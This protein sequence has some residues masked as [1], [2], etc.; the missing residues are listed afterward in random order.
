MTLPILRTTEGLRAR[1]REWRCAG[2]SVG[3][4]P[5]MGALHEGHLSLVRLCRATTARTC[6]TI[7]VNPKQFA[8]GED[9]ERY[10]RDEAADARLL[11]AEGADTLYAPDVGDVYGPG[12]A[13]RVAVGA[14]GDDLEGAFRPGFFEGIATVVTKLLM[15]ALPDTAFFGEKDYQQLVVIRRLVADLDIPVAIE[16]APTV[17]E[18]DGLAAASRNA[19]LTPAERERAP[20]LFRAMVSVAEMVDAGGEVDAACADARRTLLDSG[21]ASVDYVAV[22]DAETLGP[23]AYPARTA[24]VL[25][26]AR[27]G[28]TRLIDNVA[29]APEPGH[30]G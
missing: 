27:L 9:L 19:Y 22:R 2:E 7:F 3:L 25:A 12:F 14:V 26:A 18:A 28:T 15:K 13:T 21:F 1:I 6:V 5:T 10:P 24:R 4:V 11:D 17:R 23:P 29:V 30:D 20:R 16:A 8:P